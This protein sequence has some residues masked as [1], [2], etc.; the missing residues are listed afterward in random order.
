MTKSPT[1]VG[2]TAR[3]QR[4]TT[5]SNLRL[6]VCT[7]RH[8]HP[9]PTNTIKRPQAQ[10]NNTSAQLLC[11]P[12][13]YTCGAV[14]R[15]CKPVYISLMVDPTT[16]HRAFRAWRL[17]NCDR[18]GRGAPGCPLRRV[19]ASLSPWAYTSGILS[20]AR[21]RLLLFPPYLCL[22]NASPSP[23]GYVAQI[24]MCPAALSF[25]SA[26]YLRCHHW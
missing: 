12:E 15:C 5:P 3:M 14:T 7:N 25:T 4:I 13:F 16:R 21:V 8:P 26:V 22:F 9:E 19:S 23:Y 1:D 10:T 2:P 18:Q 6:Y 17:C 11:T 24:L 20:I